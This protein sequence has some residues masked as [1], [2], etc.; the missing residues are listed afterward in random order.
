MKAGPHIQSK[1][2]ESRYYAGEY[3]RK[4]ALLR[5]QA[6]DYEARASKEDEAAIRWAAGTD[7]ELP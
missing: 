2:S 4:A 3:R 7:I 5:K 6:D 1:V